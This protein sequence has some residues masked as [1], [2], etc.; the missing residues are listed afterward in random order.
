MFFLTLIFVTDD[1]GSKGNGGDGET[2]IRNGAIVTDIFVTARVSCKLLYKEMGEYIPP[3]DAG[4][5]GGNSNGI[6]N[7]MDI[8]FRFRPSITAYQEY[9]REN[10]AKLMD[11]SNLEHFLNG[12]TNNE[13]L[14]KK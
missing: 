13:K 4:R 3:S 1:L 5:N 2:Y 14:E 8:T 11:R 9:A 10:L 6:K 7:P 12:F